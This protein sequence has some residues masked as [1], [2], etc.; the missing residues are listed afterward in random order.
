MPKFGFLRIALLALLLVGFQETWALAG[1]TG[2]LSGTVLLT[3]GAPLAAASVSATS[4]S[5]SAS[6]TTDSTG[7]FSFVSLAPDTYTVTVSKDGYDTVAQNGVTVI[8]DQNQSV[9]LRTQ[10]TAK[11]IG[12]VTATAAALVKAG[13]TADVYSVNAATAT[14]L[15]GLGGGQNLDTAYSAIASVP[16]V[17]TSPGQSGW[18]Q[19]IHIRGGDYD[20]VGYEFDGVPVLRSYDNYPTNNASAL[21]EQELQVYTGAA[22]ANSESQGISGYINQVLKSGTYPG[23]GQASFGIGT[24][25]LY[26]K[27]SLEVGGATPN[28]NFS[29][30]LGVGMYNASQRI[31]DNSNGADVTSEWGTPFAEV[32]CNGSANPNLTS[33]YADGS[34]PGGFIN[35]PITI[36]TAFQRLQDRENLVNLHFGIPHHNDAGKDDIQLMYDTS[37]LY[38]SVYGDA[39][40][41]NQPG[42]SP[43]WL[44]IPGAYY[45][46]QLGAALP[47]NYTSFVQPYNFPN[48][49]NPNTPFAPLQT[50]HEDGFSNGQGIVKLQYQHN[51]GSSAYWRIYGY[52]FYSDWLNNAPNSLNMCCAGLPPD[53]ELNDHTR[54]LSGTY[55]NQIDSKNLITLELSQ[56]GTENYR[57][58]NQYYASHGNLAWLVSATSPVNGVCYA[59]GESS[60][61]SPVACNDANLG[62]ADFT[63][64][65]LTDELKASD[66]LIFNIGV[67]FDSYLFKTSNVNFAPG[68]AS[69]ARAF[70]FAAANLDYCQQPLTNPVLKAGDPRTACPAGFTQSQ[71]IDQGAVNETFNEF[72]PRVGFTY[73]LNHDNI[74][75]FS[76]GKY[77]SPPNMAF[78]Q[79]NVLQQNLAA[80]DLGN[81]AKFGF[82]TTTHSVRPPT[83]NNYDLSFEHQFANTAASFKLTP[84]YRQTKDQVQTFFLDQ[85]TNFVSG[86]N[87]GSLTASGVEFELNDG[88][89]NE[90]GLAGLLSYTYTHAAIKYA[91]FANGLTVIDTINNQIKT[92]NSYTSF[93]FAHP[94]DGRCG[95]TTNGLASAACYAPDGDPDPS[96]GSGDIAN[97]YWNAPAQSLFNTSASYE[98]YGLIP[99]VIGSSAIGYNVPDVATLVVNYKRDKWNVTPSLQF[100]SGAKYGAPLIQTGI[101]PAAGCASLGT[102]P[103]GDPRY[104]YGAAGGNAYDALTC[105]GTLSGI[106]DPV[107][108]QFDN[109][110]AFTQPSEILGNISL[111]YDATSRVSFV[112]TFAN[113]LN[114]CFGGSK[115]PWTK[116]ADHRV[117]SYGLDNIANGGIEPTAN[118]YNPG[119]TFDPATAYGYEQSFTA[120]NDNGSAPYLPLQ[121]QLEMKI[122]L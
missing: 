11:I 17:S 36:L 29:Y 69:S 59:L 10:V 4:P 95:S 96:C 117:C 6:T 90:N 39:R 73:N 77:T 107:T 103:T 119:A 22:P 115:E 62:R 85:R 54:G 31:I 49:I 99:G 60:A 92:Y 72:E 8:A 64:A 21:G 26:N 43:V 112:A 105:A 97:P 57:D 24:P 88:N 81:F 34:G 51:I 68:T 30:Y 102:S 46:G 67:R 41:F 118:S 104:P 55:A 28:R 116:F 19:T 7:H 1:T 25:S 100:F 15:T 35:S 3:S 37:E 12:H 93:C 47:A 108:K 74:I 45:A 121:V 106:P 78:E 110:G 23:F 27:A 58:Y 83:A 79:Y 84:F 52:T 16:G 42:Y 20:Q 87:T 101:D 91:P 32:P 109:L 98:P 50:N 120:P 38:T 56:I 40:D 33:C 66:A 94:T 61:A 122:K 80:Y 53:Y 48:P 44:N 13:T 89:F 71:L 113:V 65:S 76:Y 18:F 86:L 75:R 70:W 82:T 114:D 111:S 14:K 9:N 5:Q 63:A 2:S